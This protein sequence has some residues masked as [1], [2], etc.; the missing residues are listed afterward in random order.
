MT[1][2]WWWSSIIAMQERISSIHNASANDRDGLVAPKSLW[3]SSADDEL[4]QWYKDRDKLNRE[5]EVL[6]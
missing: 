5:P 2:P 4:D 1:L 6:E 3:L